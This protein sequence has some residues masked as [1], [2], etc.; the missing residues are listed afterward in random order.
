M[1]LYTYLNYGGN[2]EQAFRFYEQHLGGKITDYDGL[3]AS[4]PACSSPT[5]RRPRPTSS[6]PRGRRPL[7]AVLGL[8]DHGQ[9]VLRWRKIIRLSDT[10]HPV[11]GHHDDYYGDV[12]W[13][14]ELA[15][16]GTR[17]SCTTPSPSPAGGSAS[18]TCRRISQDLKEVDPESEAEIKAYNEFAREHEHLMAKSLFCAGTTWPGVF[19]AEDQRALDYLA[20]RPD[21][22]PA[23]SAAR[24]LRRRPSHRL[25][26]R[27][28]RPHPV[29]LLRGHDDHLA[30][31]SAQ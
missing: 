15:R 2:C 7:P 16:R 3:R 6:S 9:Q 17:C 19:T 24:P 18:P 11:M 4:A 29:C 25:S 23:A 12:G 28:R 22:D 21:V 20:A 27:S 1:K 31:L 8:H 26:R 14:N 30:R 10:L 13:A 5:D